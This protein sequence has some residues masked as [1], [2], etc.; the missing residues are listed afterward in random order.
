MVINKS[1]IRKILVIR[2]DAIGDVILTTPFIRELRRNFSGAFISLVVDQKAYNLVE[3]CPYVNEVLAFR[4]LR[5]DDKMKTIKAYLLPIWFAFEYFRGKNFDL[6][7]LP[8]WDTDWYGAAYLAFLSG[9]RIRVG[10]SENINANKAIWNRG[11]DS[12]LTNVIDIRDLKHEVERNLNVLHFLGLEVLD[13]RLEL[14]TSKDDELFADFTLKI[15]GVSDNDILIA[16]APGASWLRKR[17]PI[18][19][20]LAVCKWISKRYDAKFLVLGGK[21]EEELGSF[22]E[23]MLED[24]VINLVSK[25]TLRQAVALLKRSKL[26]IGND[27][28]PMHMASACGIP[29]VALFCHPKNGDPASHHSPIR[30]GPWKT[31]SIVL[32]PE[33]AVSPCSSECKADQPHCILGI[34]VDQVIDAVSSLLDGIIY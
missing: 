10:Y 12:F 15:A 14:W 32:Q 26:F 7:L 3:V 2:L 33:R 30:F 22:L 25:T 11:F 4:N 27:S 31:K 24:R 13:D 29:L 8:R 19:R 18:E 1:K 17:W 20:F 9:A 5:M 28:S 21:G 6:A 23:K 16:I 34:E